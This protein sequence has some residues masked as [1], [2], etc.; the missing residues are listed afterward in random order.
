M[1]MTAVTFPLRPPRL[2]FAVCGK[3]WQ[4]DECKN[5][6]YRKLKLTYNAIVYQVFPWQIFF[7]RNQ[8]AGYIFFLNLAIPHLKSQMST[9]EARPKMAGRVNH[10]Y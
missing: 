9:P 7:P 8:S 3:R 6:L 2:A 5:N 1:F 10:V 4:N